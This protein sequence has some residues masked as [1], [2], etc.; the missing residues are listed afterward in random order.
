M[1]L[2]SLPTDKP[3][4]PEWKWERID[5]PICQVCGV[6]ATRDMLRLRR[7]RYESD[8][9]V[10]FDCVRIIARAFRDYDGDVVIGDNEN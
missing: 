1:I 2:H 8:Q 3:K 4:E 10:C 9:H 7:W 6:N 5:L